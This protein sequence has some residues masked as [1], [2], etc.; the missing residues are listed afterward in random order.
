MGNILIENNYYNYIDE[1]LEGGRS[2]VE[3]AKGGNRGNQ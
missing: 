1:G 3:G 2:W